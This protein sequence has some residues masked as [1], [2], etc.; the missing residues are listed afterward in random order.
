MFDQAV[1]VFAEDKE[2]EMNYRLLLR[3]RVPS[4]EDTVLCLTAASFYRLRVNGH[5]VAFGPARTAKGYARIDEISLTPDHR[6][7]ENEIEIEVAGYACSALS[8]VRQAS[9]VVAE[10]R[11]ADEVLLATGRAGDF[12]GFCNQSSLQ[13]MERYSQQRHFCEAYDLR[14]KETSVS[15]TKVNT[16]LTYLPRVAPYPTFFDRVWVDGACS[17]GSFFSDETLPYLPMRVNTTLD[18][19]WQSYPEEQLE[20]QAYRWFQ[21]QRRVSGSGASDFPLTLSAGEYVMIDFGRVEV[22]H[23][24]W[25]AEVAE[26]AELVLAFSEH[27]TPEE[28]AFTQSTVQNVIE[29][30]LPKGYHAPES[31]SPYAAR[32]A[33]LMVKSGSLT[34]TG[35]GIRTHE[36]NCFGMS[37]RPVHDPELRAIYHAAVR[38]F[39]HNAVDLYTDC[40]SR[41]RAGFLCDSYFLAKTEYFLTGKSRVEDAFLENYRLYRGDGSLPD[42]A[43]P[44]CYPS[45]NI[46]KWIPQWTLWYVLEV[47]EYLTER[48]PDLDR[49]MFRASVYGVMGLIETYEND[50]GLLERL[51]SW[52]FVESTRANRWT[53]EVSYPTN[54]LYAAALAAAGA[55][56][57][58]TRLCD[59]AKRLRKKTEELSFDGLLFAD[60]AVRGEDGILR[61]QADFSEAGQYYAILFGEIDLSDERY[62]AL[63]G[64]VRDR[65]AAVPLEGRDFEPADAFIGDALRVL[66]LMKLGEIALLKKDLC[67]IFGAMAKQT[68][69]FWEHRAPSTSLDHGFASFVMLA[70]DLVEKNEKKL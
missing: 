29:W 32:Y 14:K 7:G 3:A 17:H 41:E 54:F 42:G 4:L 8:T 48:R 20:S 34:V 53:Q 15:L 27:C 6:D 16:H 22:G 38:T 13:R 33:I 43:L 63:R 55:L 9:F 58:D 62:A 66:C 68:E 21:G 57:D 23:F 1:P 69:T 45:D 35:F 70:I 50:E 64:F 49:E 31:F 11:R 47:V 40:P 30:I 67:E 60:H 18:V 25:S 28:F 51:P 37:H 24:L 56:Y 46:G 52:N 10:L 61:N 5:F 59:K 2:W 44:M 26:E 39:A 65:F 36:F 12:E 19:T